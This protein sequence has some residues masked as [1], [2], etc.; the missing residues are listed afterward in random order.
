M[1]RLSD[2]AIDT[3]VKLCALW[4]STMFCYVYCDYFE[5]YRPGKLESMLQGTIGSW[6]VTQ[7]VLMGT[8]ILMAVPSLM[9]FLSVA[10]PARY[11]R[12][13]NIV[14]GAFFTLLLTLIAFTAGWYFY[15]FFAA[16]ETGLTALVVW[17]AWKW[18]KAEGAVQEHAPLGASGL[19]GQAINKE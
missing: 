14:V 5:L 9:I 7:S 11:N 4:A 19:R 10:L 2:V 8:S 1:S 3:K 18:P 16:L 13:L 12:V 17:Y 6:S 15:K